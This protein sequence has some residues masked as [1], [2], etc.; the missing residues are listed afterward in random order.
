MK[1]KI[2]IRLLWNIFLNNTIRRK[3]IKRMREE[4]AY[5]KMRREYQEYDGEFLKEAGVRM[6][7]QPEEFEAWLKTTHLKQTI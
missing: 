5:E 3:K 1:K 2:T 7:M 6:Y 4:S